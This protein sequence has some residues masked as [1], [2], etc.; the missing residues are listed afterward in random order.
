MQFS[1]SHHYWYFPASTPAETGSTY[2]RFTSNSNHSSSRT[3]TARASSTSDS[4]T[5][6]S[7]TS[8]PSNSAPSN[9][10]YIRTPIIRTPI[11]RTPTVWAQSTPMSTA[12]RDPPR[13]LASIPS[14]LLGPAESETR[15]NNST[16]GLFRRNAARPARPTTPRPILSSRQDFLDSEPE[17]KRPR[18]GPKPGITDIECKSC[19]GMTAK[20]F[21]KSCNH[22]FSTTVLN[23]G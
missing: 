9:S 21:L 22:F 2:A 12:S 10:A 4:S 17:P 8:A 5:S 15:S 3:P 18:R 1:K 23:S 11:I 13:N 14:F 19:G 20:A 6:D 16:E 7:S